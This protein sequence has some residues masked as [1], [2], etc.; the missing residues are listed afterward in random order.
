M[1]AISVM[2]QPTEKVSERRCPR[3]KW[4]CHALRCGAGDIAR[5]A[6]SRAYDIGLGMTDREAKIA[7]DDHVCR[8]MN[9][10]GS[11]RNAVF[12]C[13][14]A[15]SRADGSLDAA[16]L[17]RWWEK[18]CAQTP[19]EPGGGSCWKKPTRRRRRNTP[20]PAQ[21]GAT[22]WTRWAQDRIYAARQWAWP[23]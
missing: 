10:M 16:R 22:T 6:P 4:C 12:S 20:R 21:L 17:Y 15:M 23:R 8:T 5:K 9:C 19:A 18:N 2:A 1:M 3:S 14:H 13:L 7:I 11:R